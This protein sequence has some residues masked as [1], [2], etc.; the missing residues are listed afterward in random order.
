MRKFLL[1]AI[2]CLVIVVCY[3]Q[4]SESAMISKIKS[5]DKNG[6]ILNV[7]L[8]GSGISEKV[9]EDGAWHS[10]YRRSYKTKSKT[11]YTGI[12][13][14]YFGA[15]QYEL[16]GGSYQYD[17]M[18]VGDWNYEGVPD[19]NKDEIL[20]LLNADLIK[21]LGRNTYN[22]I[23]GDLSEITF[24]SDIKFHWHEL[25]SVSFLTKVTY[26]EKISSTEVR[27]AE[28][29]IEVRLYADEFKGPWK[30]FM[31][32]KKDD[33][34]SKNSGEIIKYTAEEMAQMKTLAELD[35]ENAAKAFLSSLPEVEDVPVFESDKQMFYYIHE[36]VMTKPTEE[37]KA[38][39]YK[40]LEPSCYEENSTVLLKS[41]AQ[42]WYDNVGANHQ[43]YID[44]H[45][46]Y[47]TVKAYQSGMITFYD[48]ENR[49]MLRMVGV[50][51]EGTYK[52]REIDFYPA[53]ASDIER[54][55]ANDAN[56]GEKPDLT[57]RKVI[58]YEVGDKVIGIFSNGEFPGFVDKKDPYNSNRYF[59]KL[60]GDNSGK[61]Y[62]M[63]EVNMKPNTNP[64]QSNANNADNNQ[65]EETTKTQDVTF[66]V[67]DKV[68]VNTTQGKKKG[69]IIKYAS[70]KY[71]VKFIDQRYGETWVAN[72]NLEKD[73]K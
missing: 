66:N 20:A 10:Y 27:K 12:Y 55:K 71:L 4:P 2:S 48:R 40:V 47:P 51:N 13:L 38:Y 39:L 18:L 16:I 49:R 15:I 22:D 73:E 9:Y 50:E 30:S 28:H 54:M 29:T 25:T 59:V 6:K 31:S 65:T 53:P 41:W 44:A 64:Q 3:A 60:D 69:K 24:P 63:D 56:C 42:K 72:G 11:D 35:E 34:S 70:H 68:I 57:V 33:G 37:V 58:S 32:T 43:A 52:L 46:M 62:W 8:L 17:N 5:G 26:S 21:Y 23:V 1:L 67:G 7:E 61:G 45:C 14:I 19:P 36:I